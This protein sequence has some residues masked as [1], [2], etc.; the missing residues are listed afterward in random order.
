MSICDEMVINS[1]AASLPNY[2]LQDTSNDYYDYPVNDTKIADFEDNQPM[3]DTHTLIEKRDAILEIHSVFLKIF[4]EFLMSSKYISSFSTEQIISDIANT[5]LIEIENC[6]KG[7]F[8]NPYFEMINSKINYMNDEAESWLRSNKFALKPIYTILTTLSHKL[9][10]YPF[11]YDIELEIFFDVEEK[12]WDTFR[13]V[14]KPKDI[15]EEDFS[16]LMELWDELSEKSNDVLN[17]LSLKDE[18]HT[19]QI[20]D[21]K[22]K[23]I[24]SIDIE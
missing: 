6:S 16:T 2:P 14:I 20:K 23:L 18:T 15:Q 10:T 24:V 4:S 5:N 1:D 17:K 21:F 8:M 11:E 22:S 3:S 12:D 19:N 9:N 13:M 7:R